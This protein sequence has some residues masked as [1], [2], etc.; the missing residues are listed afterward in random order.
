MLVDKEKEKYGLKG[1]GLAW[2]HDTMDS[3]E[4]SHLM[5]EM[6]KQIEH[7]FHEPQVSICETFRLL[8]GQG[9]S[10]ED[11]YRL[12]KLKRALK[13]ALEKCPAADKLPLQVESVLIGMAAITK[14]TIPPPC[15]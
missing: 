12:L 4:A 9:Y 6:V 1:L 14:K 8:R 5:V 7:G 15:P 11:I 2:K 3:A 10:P 13:M